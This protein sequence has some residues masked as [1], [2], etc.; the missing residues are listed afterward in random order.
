MRTLIT[1]K[2]DLKILD[3]KFE[4]AFYLSSGRSGHH[5]GDLPQ[6]DSSGQ[7]HLSRV[8]LQ[9]VQ[10]SLLV[11]RRELNLAIDATG[12]EQGRVKDVDAVG[13]HDD[14]DVLRSLEAVQL[15]EQL[16]HGALHF[17]VTAAAGLDP[18][19]SDGVDLVHEDDGGRVLAGHDE[20]LADH[21]GSFSDELL[22]QLGSGDPDEC[23]LGVVGDGASQERLSSSGRSVEENS[24]GLGD[25]QGVEELWMFDRKF[26]DLLDLLNLL[27]Q[28]ADHLVGRVRHFL[29]HH[30]R[31]LSKENNFFA[32][33]K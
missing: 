1:K 8:D 28:T 30:E 19:R 14:L 32:A 5:L 13:G 3:Q 6:V 18:G 20:Q 2:V 7:V 9:D 11:R 25:A 4:N 16:E 22:D 17:G 12:T 33:C 31:D 29:D 21:P 23:A 10:T 27:G 24:L 26:D 15:V